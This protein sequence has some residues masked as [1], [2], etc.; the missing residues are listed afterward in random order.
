VQTLLVASG[1]GHL[2]QLARLLPRLQIESDSVLVSYEH[3]QIP[4]TLCRSTF[5]A[6]HHPTTKN[7]PNA[8]RNYRLAVEVFRRHPIRRV[9]STGAGVAVPFLVEARRLG[10]PSHYIESATRVLGPSLSG[11]LAQHLAGV[12]LYHQLGAWSGSGR[13]QQGPSVFDG[14]SSLPISKPRASPP[15]VFASLGTHRYPFRSFVD[16]VYRVSELRQLPVCWQ[17]GATPGPAGVE[18][19]HDRLLSPPEFAAAVEAADVIVGHAGVGL[20]LD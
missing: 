14:F 4:A 18:G 16:A 8:L 17:L 7:L 20:A 13:W 1:G 10:I 2:T 11:R 5:V 15:T 3:H 12:H 6:A 9:V 19:Q